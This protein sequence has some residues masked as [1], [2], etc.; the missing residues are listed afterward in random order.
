MKLSLN[1]LKDYVDIDK[2]PQD[3]ADLLT[4]RGLEVEGIEPLGKSLNGIVAGKILAF[5]KHPRAD[6]L[7]VCQVDT[8]NDQVGVVCGASNLK[9]GS[10]VPMA[11]PGTELPGGTVVKESVIR[12]E[13]SMGMLL[14]EDEMGLTDDH[15]G[16]M[17]LPDNLAP[18]A[19]LVSVLPLMDHILDIS[20]TPN[21]PD[22]ASVIG[23]AREVAAS[24]GQ[25]VKLPEI[26]YEERGPRI[27][28]ITSVTVDDTGGCP[29][30]AAGMIQGV[31]L[32]SSPFWIRYR[33]FT[34]GIRAINNVVDVSNY[35]LLEMGQPL[36]TFDFDRL[37]GH[38]IIVTR[39]KDGDV[40]T[41]LDGQNRELNRE[42]LMICD[43]EGPVALAGIMG[44][45]NSEI[46]A[47]SKDILIESACFDPI[48]IRRGAKA[49]GLSTEAS[50]RFER[51]IDIEG[52]IRALRRSLMLIS[53]L[54]GG[55]INKGIIDVYPKPYAPSLID[56]RVSKT[57]DLLGTSIS[58]ESMIS[59][60]ES[61]EMEVR[62]LDDNRLQVKPPTFR[63][64]VTR[65][66]D[67]MEEIA[68]M[69]GYEN[70]QVTYPSI[71]LS[72]EI[73][74][75][76]ESLQEKVSW[77]MTGLGFS[78]IITY[79]F[80]SH[81]SADMLGAKA[82]SYIRAFVELKNPLTID[83]AVMRTSLV[84]G[85]LYTAK[86]NIA[87][88]EKAL[89]LFEW[90]KIFLK[91]GPGPLPHEKPFLAGMMTG[92]YRPKEWYENARLT[93]FYDI[94]GVVEVL[95]R[96]L[97]IKDVRFETN[98][99]EPWYHPQFSCSI[100]VADSYVG[101]LGQAAPDVIE[102]YDLR[103]EKAYL[104]EVDIEAL[105]GHTSRAPVKF[106][107]FSNYPAVIRDLSIIVDGRVESGLICDIIQREGNSLVESVKVFD[108][109]EGKKTGPDKKTLSFRIIYRSKEGT[110]DGDT[111]NSL[112]EKIIDVLT[113]ETGGS[114]G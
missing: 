41:T 27:E 2:S 74:S 49:L 72:E 13:R 100:L 35:V 52:V 30:Y 31:Q 58:K 106:E 32:K 17:I 33:L 26:K 14:A 19:E 60:L 25:Q 61:L 90:G 81:D 71:K 57:N 76:T 48:T 5:E 44:G 39:A 6:R 97:G 34:S 80:V 105:L 113:Q 53:S 104:F 9:E 62:D 56:V 83:Q 73:E 42:H 18:G 21:R 66:V 16:I 96:S 94:K 98:Q 55:K 7:F 3:L 99:P 89:K 65:E 78:E 4:M 108:L 47:D 93:D 50:Y 28:E 92:L 12:G 91:S 24:T 45:M 11:L 8:G 59:Y 37:G 102:R 29:R 46:Y 82:E 75:P 87:R 63:V 85:L 77:I 15:T 68:R 107:P 109:Y 88:G 110:L 38:R 51:G 23:I 1:W 36:H 70:I 95:F 20:L 22:C 40:F 10:M 79:S 43:A 84:P 103:T 67:L 101:C 114:L 111:V 86:E 64:D 112:H 54:A 69:E